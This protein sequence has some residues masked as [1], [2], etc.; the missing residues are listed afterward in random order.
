MI[1]GANEEETPESRAR[2]ERTVLL[3]LAAVQFTSIVDFMIV[4]PLG[5]QLM[6]VLNIGPD[7][8][9]LIV[10]SYTFAAGV[11]G[12]IASMF[13][14]RIGRKTA[15]LTLYVGFLIGTLLCG[16]A[17]NY[18]ALLAARV[19]T[20]AFGGVLGGLA[21]AI[22]GDVFPDQR[23]GRATGVLMSAFA[24]A[25]VAGVP[26]GLMLGTRYGWH[27]PF[28]MLAGLG[29]PV[30][31]VGAIVLPPL[32]DHLGKGRHSHPLRSL[33]ETFSEPNHLNAF[34][35]IAM[36]MVGSFAVVSYVSPF[37]VANCGVSETLLPLVYIAGGACTLIS[38]PIVGRMADRYGKLRV[39]RCMAPASAAVMFLITILPKAG[40]GLA[41][42]MVAALMV[43]NSGRMVPA[44][45][46]VTGSVEP[47]RRG[48][49]LSANAS[50]QHISAGIG[51]YIGSQII[52]KAPDG[53]LEHYPYVGLLAAVTGLLSLWLAGRL[54]PAGASPSMSPAASLAAAAEANADAGEALAALPGE[55]GA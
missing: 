54:R 36:L 43:F 41:A 34:A 6:R 51:A 29:L 12:L 8:F 23:R 33:V 20:G 21:M 15:F 30:L 4:M 27:V 47:R 3:T 31:F 13:I 38:S 22:I 24:L 39:Y 28:L 55:R 26:F 25:S 35:L 5:P 17:P 9:G 7:R 2:F 18:P 14:D 52:T 50:V 42:L 48:G 45:A 53:R 16:L 11:A 10:S 49:F 37:L 40:V 19:A 44:M 32:R 46:M 1:D